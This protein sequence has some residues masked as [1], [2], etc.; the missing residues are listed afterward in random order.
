MYNPT[1]QALQGH[2]YVGFCID[3][4]EKLQEV[5]NFDY[6][7]YLVPDGKFGS[8]DPVAEQWDGIM[9]EIIERVR[10]FVWGQ[11]NIA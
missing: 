9:R 11:F 10:S 2:P 8:R 5:I 6:D 4:L 1:V 3:I 7:I